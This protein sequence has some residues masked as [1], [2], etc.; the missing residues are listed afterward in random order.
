MWRRYISKTKKFFT[1][2]LDA[3]LRHNPE[4][5]LKDIIPSASS[6]DHPLADKTQNKEYLLQL[7]ENLAPKYREILILR[8]IEQKNYKEIAKILKI[9]N[10]AVSTRLLRAREFLRKNLIKSNKL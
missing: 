2:S 9:S 3:P 1:L 10:T 7:I 6:I 5:T 8:I 4:Q